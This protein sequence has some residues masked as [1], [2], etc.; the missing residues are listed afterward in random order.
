M[1]VRTLFYGWR[2]WHCSGLLLLWDEVVPL[3]VRANRSA[4]LA[5]LLLRIL[6]FLAV[7]FLAVL[8]LCIYFFVCVLF[9]VSVLFLRILF[10]VLPLLLLVVA[11][12]SVSYI[13]ASR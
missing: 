11:V 10:L 4:L 9:L 12:H 3:S 2:T 7:L 6:L 5:V 13:F 1:L 8:F